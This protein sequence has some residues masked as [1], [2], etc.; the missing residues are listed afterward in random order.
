MTQAAYA[1]KIGSPRSLH[2]IVYFPF[3]DRNIIR[4]DP[5]QEPMTAVGDM[6]WYSMRAVVEYLRPEGRITKVAVAP[7]RD[8]KTNAIVRALGLIAFDG[9]QVSTFDIG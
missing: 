7:E 2:T 9:G 6:A 3:T 1:D 5:A 4:F 8:L